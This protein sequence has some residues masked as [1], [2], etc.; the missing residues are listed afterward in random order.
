M[1]VP[2][3]WRRTPILGIYKYIRMTKIFYLTPSLRLLP[4]NTSYSKTYSLHPSSSMA[5]KKTVMEKR[6][7]IGS[8]SLVP[9]PHP[10]NHDKFITLE[11]EKLYHESLHNRNFV[12]ECNFSD[13]NVHFSF[14]IQEK[15]WTKFC[16]H[17]PPGIA[18]MVKEFHFILRYQ[19]DTIV[20]VRWP[21]FNTL[22]VR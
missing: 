10:K 6:K 17:P 14:M 11:A 12:V 22:T 13:S 2:L 16:E 20:Y 8:S 21:F 4:P 7:R 18:L 19:I 15:G 3:L 1:K 5:L 9:L